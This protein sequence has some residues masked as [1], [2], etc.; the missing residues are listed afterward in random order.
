MKR[1]V[2]GPDRDQ[3]FL[4]SPSLEDYVDDDNPVRVVD[5]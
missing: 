4:L 5:A 2:V 3:T 1:F